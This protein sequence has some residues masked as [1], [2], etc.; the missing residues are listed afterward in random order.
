M[1]NLRGVL[2]F[3]SIPKDKARC[4]KAPSL[5]NELFYF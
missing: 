2:R 1:I 4:L 3:A 5:G